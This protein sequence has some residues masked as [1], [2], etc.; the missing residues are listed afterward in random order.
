VPE[1][2]VPDV[3]EAPVPEGDD[4]IEETPVANLTPSHRIAD[5]G[6][7]RELPLP[8]EWRVKRRF[9]RRIALFSDVLLFGIISAAFLLSSSS[10]TSALLHFE[11][12]TK[13][14]AVA[15]VAL[16]PNRNGTIR[17]ESRDGTIDETVD[18]QRFLART[19]IRPKIV[20]DRFA[21]YLGVAVVLS[22]VVLPAVLI[23]I[24]VTERRRWRRVRHQI[25]LA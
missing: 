2:P 6:P 25:G 13:G 1:A 15:E 9:R 19:D 14:G 17:I 12:P 20:P 11:V 5:T 3:P 24:A 23:A 16:R 21:V 18:A 4:A 7:I 10:R 8:S 22:Y